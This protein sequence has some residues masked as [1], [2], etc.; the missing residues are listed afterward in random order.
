ALSLS[1]AMTFGMPRQFAGSDLLL[2]SL[3]SGEMGEA[4]SSWPALWEAAGKAT[5]WTTWLVA[6]RLAAAR[7]E[8][9]LHAETAESAVEWAQRSLVIARRT[10]RRKYEARSL[11]TLGEAL[12]RLRRRDEALDALRRAVAIVDD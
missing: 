12:V 5:A 2:T 8:I 1:A 11:T 3:L 7:A 6:G 9:A 10:K 4:Q